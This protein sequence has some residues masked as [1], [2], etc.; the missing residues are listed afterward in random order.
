MGR[1]SCRKINTS[2]IKSQKNMKT[3]FII[4]IF[5]ALLVLSCEKDT[6]Q[7]TG[8]ITGPDL[9]MCV[10][11]GGYFL[12][13]D[14]TLYLFE[15]SELPDGFTFTDDELPLKVELNWKP[16]TGGCSGFNRIVISKIKVK[17]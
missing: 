14:G 17:P 13:M 4:L 6:Y 10:C 5:S 2:F 16:K 15:Q 7:S 11:C 8:T 1:K 9:R 3:R 12:D